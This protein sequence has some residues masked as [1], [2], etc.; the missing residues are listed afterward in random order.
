MVTVRSSAEKDR[1]RRIFNTSRVESDP[2]VEVVL[3]ISRVGSGGAGSGREAVFE[4]HGVRVTRPG[5]K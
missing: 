3:E 5:E 2:V 1:V 4:S